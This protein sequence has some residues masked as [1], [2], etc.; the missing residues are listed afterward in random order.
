[1]AAVDAYKRTSGIGAGTAWTT[2]STGAAFRAF[3]AWKARGCWGFDLFGAV[4]TVGVGIH[5]EAMGRRAVHQILASAT[6]SE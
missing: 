5:N 3:S 2:P 6:R 4:P 1:M